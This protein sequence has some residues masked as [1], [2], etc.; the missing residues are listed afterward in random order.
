M[1]VI[2][3]RVCDGTTCHLWFKHTTQQEETPG[4][5]NKDTNNRPE[6]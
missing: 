6:Q 3:T 4:T 5:M 2:E 1:H